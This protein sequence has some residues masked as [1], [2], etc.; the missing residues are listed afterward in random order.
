[1]SSHR[2]KRPTERS[3]E[4][5]RV[6]TS[7]VRPGGISVCE[8]IRGGERVVFREDR[9]SPVRAVVRFCPGIV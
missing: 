8:L 9:V 3:V 5:V 6:R 7:Y 4:D 2:L 1:M